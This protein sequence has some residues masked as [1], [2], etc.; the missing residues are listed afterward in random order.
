MTFNEL[1]VQLNATLA[2]FAAEVGEDV[3]SGNVVDVTDFS[4]APGTYINSPNQPWTSGTIPL[5]TT[6]SVRGGI[7]AIWYKGPVLTKASFTGGVVTMFSGV[8][9]LDQLCRVFIDYDK[10][11]D[12]F[13]INIQTG[14]TGDLPAEKA[15]AQMTINS[16]VDQDL[17]K[18]QKMT[19]NSV[20]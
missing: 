20:T 17:T 14:F 13:G 12:C 15:P 9:A 2:N 8:N 5:D 19:I 1:I 4:K 7:A 3:V 18:P 11:S 10:D 16:V 6:G